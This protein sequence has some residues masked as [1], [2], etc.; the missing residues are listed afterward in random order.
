MIAA[1]VAMRPQ[2][3]RLMYVLAAKMAPNTETFSVVANF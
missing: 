3:A 1:W 2:E